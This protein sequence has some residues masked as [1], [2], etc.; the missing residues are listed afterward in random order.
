MPFEK[1]FVLKNFISPQDSKEKEEEKEHE[2]DE[3]GEEEI[4]NES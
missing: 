1:F 3:E 2:I 4:N